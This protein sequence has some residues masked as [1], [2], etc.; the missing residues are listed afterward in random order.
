MLCID[1]GVWW[2]H[3]VSVNWWDWIELVST[4]ERICNVTCCCEGRHS[5]FRPLPLQ[6]NSKVQGLL[7]NTRELVD[8]REALNRIKSLI[9][10][11]TVTS[12][13]SYSS[14][15]SCAAEMWEA[16]SAELYTVG[17]TE[18]W[19]AWLV[20]TSWCNGAYLVL[21]RLLNHNGSYLVLMS[22]LL[23]YRLFL[24]LCFWSTSGWSIWSVATTIWEEMH[25]FCS[26][27]WYWNDSWDAG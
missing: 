19:Q 10:I 8:F 25:K 1:T 11:V 16:D 2:E 9:G 13:L 20:C 12:M 15:L 23:E 14:Q 4:Y 6:W 5:D 22:W 21:K 17:R 7:K 27:C 18:C 24:E 3:S 26:N